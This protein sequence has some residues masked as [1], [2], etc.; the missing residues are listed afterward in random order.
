MSAEKK[1]LGLIGARG[2][3]GSEL[4]K[5]LAHHPYFTVDF[6][7]SRTHPGEPVPGLPDAR[8]ED[9]DAAAIAARK[10]DAVVL[11]LPND[12][13][14]PV[15]AAIDAVHPE[16]V[17]VDVSADHRFD[18][19]W[20]YGLPEHHRAA[21][22]G[23]R[24]IANPGCYATATALALRPL[25]ALLEGPAHAFGVSGY[26]G[27]GTTPSPR[28]DVDALRD[29]L[30][31]YALTGHLHER[32]VCRHAAPVCFVPHVASFFRG[33]TV[34]VSMIFERPVSKGEL[35][36]RYN[37]AYGGEPLVHIVDDIPQVRE[38][39]NHPGAVIGGITVDEARRHAVVIATLDN[40]LKGAASQAVQ[41]LNLA[42]GFPETTG[43]LPWKSR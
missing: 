21:Q 29:N 15:V 30:I 1:R 18:P 9:L 2:Y 41:N 33:L 31:P 24:R 5:L 19:T 4:I 34:T 25:A 32:E 12:L 37:E 22:K 39:A 8:V 3:V 13:S 16:T 36:I 38:I 6:V 43:I 11:A 42:F 28:N 14:L 27:A 35:A 17:I 7:S 40:L 26:S 10:A 20:V 23:A